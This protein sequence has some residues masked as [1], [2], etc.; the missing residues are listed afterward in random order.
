MDTEERAM[1][2]AGALRTVTG[3]IGRQAWAP[4]RVDV[5][6]A[7]I[8]RYAEAIG[9]PAPAEPTVAPP[10]FLPPFA[11]GGVVA[12]DGRRRRP[13]EVAIDH[14][15]LRRRLMGGCSVDFH[16]PIRAGETIEAV[17]TFESVVEKQGRDG[18]MLLVTTATEYR[19][20]DGPRRTERWTIIH[21]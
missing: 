4:V 7:D 12:P 3:L 21:R 1:D 11:V 15:A 18:P 8:L 20:P 19:T 14:P 6:E 16:A 17:T 13:A 9:L 5:R 10:L 2:W